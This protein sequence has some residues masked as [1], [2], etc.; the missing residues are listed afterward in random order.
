MIDAHECKVHVDV[1][2]GGEASND[3]GVVRTGEFLVISVAIAH[4]FRTF[5]V[6]ANMRRHFRVTRNGVMLCLAFGDNYVK[7]NEDTHTVRDKIFVRNLVYGDKRYMRI[8]AGH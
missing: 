3:R 4:I 6:E 2:F 7:A 5:R 8:F 1:G